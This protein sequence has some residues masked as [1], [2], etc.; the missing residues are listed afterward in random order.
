MMIKA[1]F[2]FAI[3]LFTTLTY[4]ILEPKDFS[5]QANFATVS[6][7]GEIYG[8]RGCE[9]SPSGTVECY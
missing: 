9:R 7:S 3:V 8:S 2:T 1:I 6:P 4:A 5:P